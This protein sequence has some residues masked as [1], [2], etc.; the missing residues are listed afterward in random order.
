MSLLEP[1]LHAG[2]EAEVALT[3]VSACEVVAEAGQLIVRIDQADGERAANRDVHAAADRN[4]EGI[5]RR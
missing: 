2:L 5:V 4:C 3:I 1:E